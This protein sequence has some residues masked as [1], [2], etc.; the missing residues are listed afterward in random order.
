MTGTI[1]R[2]P[3]QISAQTKTKQDARRC[4]QFDE[5]GMRRTIVLPGAYVDPRHVPQDA[6]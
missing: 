2:Q 4:G 5:E 6:P 1:M 3:P